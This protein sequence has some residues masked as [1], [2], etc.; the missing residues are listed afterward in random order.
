[1]IELNLEKGFD[2]ASIVTSFLII[3]GSILIYL[4]RTPEKRHVRAKKTKGK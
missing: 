2:Y 4:M 3:G 1:M